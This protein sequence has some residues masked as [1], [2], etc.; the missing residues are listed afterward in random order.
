MPELNFIQ[1]ILFISTPIPDH[2]PST[3]KYK[4]IFKRDSHVDKTA[5]CIIVYP[6]IILHFSSTHV[7]S[8]S[9]AGVLNVFLSHIM[10]EIQH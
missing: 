3:G 2:P 5:D 6:T 1:Q 7:A 4:A 8:P 10:D 9:S